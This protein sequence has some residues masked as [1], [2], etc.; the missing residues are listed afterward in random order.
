M[1]A[2]RNLGVAH[3]TAPYLGF[4]DA[5]D[6]WSPDKLAEQVDLLEN[7]PD[8]AMV[9]GAI[10]YW[11]SWDRAATDEDFVLL[12]GG[13]ADL[14][15][16]PPDAALTFL[17]LGEKPN[18]GMDL[19]V[20]HSVFGAVGGFE[21]S[22]RDLFEDQAFIIKVLLRYPI[23]VSSRP[24]LRYRRHDAS[25][26]GRATRADFL[27]VRGD[28]LDWFREDDERLR[29]SRVSARVRR[30]RR[31]LRYLKL[32]CLLSDSLPP[33]F[34]RRVKRALA[35]FSTKSQEQSAHHPASSGCSPAPPITKRLQ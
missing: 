4:L 7:M 29:D 28:F 34:K 11:H 8:V 24:W 1:S 32:Y 12:T 31:E 23:Y 16:D 14:R 33:Q 10:Q 35:P 17:P 13:V 21:E 26:L 5:D 6:V 18:A 3:A 25:C 19:L 20:R 22:F 2:S 30:A 9:V 27:R 15:I